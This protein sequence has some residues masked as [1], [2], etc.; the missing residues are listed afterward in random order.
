MAVR[1][2]QMEAESFSSRLIPNILIYMNY[3]RLIGNIAV[4]Y[5]TLISLNCFIAVKQY[6]FLT[7]CEGSAVF[8]CFLV[9]KKISN[10][11]ELIQ[12]DPTSCPQ[13]QKGNN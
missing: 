5:S 2:Y 1:L 13:N 10:D 9:S 7:I 11:Q 8:C 6:A 12:S 3:V 4:Y